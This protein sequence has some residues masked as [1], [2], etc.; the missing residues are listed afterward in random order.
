MQ[1]KRKWLSVA[2]ITVWVVS[3]V[4]GVFGCDKRPIDGGNE[5]EIMQPILSTEIDLVKDGQS[6]YKVVVPQNASRF[7]TFA[8][9]ELIGFFKQATGIEPEKVTDEALDV[10][11][12]NAYLSVGDT[13]VFRAS[14]ITVSESELGPCGYKLER[15]DKTVYMVGYREY[16]T[17]NAVY[18]F[19]RLSFGFRCY[20]ADEIMIAKNVK[21][22]KLLDFHLSDRPDIDLRCANYG[23]MMND[24]TFAYRMRTLLHSDVWMNIEGNYWH[25]SFNYLP[26]KTYEAEHRDWYYYGNGESKAPTQ[27]DYTNEQMRLQLV[28]NLKSYI[29]ANPTLENVTI[30]HEDNRSW[31]DNAANKALL[32]KYGTN[33]ASMILFCNK[34]AADIRAWLAATAPDRKVNIV[35]FA[36]YATEKA[37][38]RYDEQRGRYMPIDET[39]VLDKDVSVFFA[40]ITADYNCSAYDPRNA[41]MRNTLE[42]W[43]TLSDKVYLWLYSTNFSHFLVPFNSF[44]SMQS[45]YRLAK[46]ANAYYLFDQGQHSQSSAVGFSRLK[47]FLN[48]QLGWDVDAD[49]NQLT[50]EFFDNYFKG[51]SRPMRTLYESIRLHYAYLR[52]ETDMPRDI[53]ADIEKATYFPKG[54][55]DQWSKYIDEAYAAIADMRESDE[56][57]YRKLESRINLESLSVRYLLI[58]IYGGMYSDGELLRMKSQFKRDATKLGVSRYRELSG[59]INL[60]WSQWGV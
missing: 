38:V 2:W 44:D 20:Y 1:I 43:T 8:A 31:C 10:S 42:A 33:A 16:G 59:A 55:L 6:D 34:V 53:Y 18:E 4:F 56:A 22:R 51:A 21:T 30:T 11:A 5:G 45:M 39:V 52:D 47:M 32:D 35:M 26:P 54:V 60:L 46:E 58:Q 14:G 19:L 15:K 12:A 36:Y 57:L 9:E 3:T 48:A 27:L 40:P 49:V 24:S 25:N 7:E 28:E 50:D 41:N 37:P 13:T 17:L 23:D 29:L